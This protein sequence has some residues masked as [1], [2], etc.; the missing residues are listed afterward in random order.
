M[1][2]VWQSEPGKPLRIIIQN[3]G[4]ILAEGEGKFY[5]DL[6]TGKILRFEELVG[7][8]AEAGEARPAVKQG[9]RFIRI[10]AWDEL[11]MELKTQRDK[12]ER[13][14]DEKFANNILPP[15]QR[16]DFLQYSDEIREEQTQGNMALNW[17]ASLRPPFPVEMVDEMGE[18]GSAHS[19][20]ED[21]VCR[22]DPESGTWSDD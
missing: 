15:S 2:E 22:Y 6:K 18:F 3:L 13:D 20:D 14:R 21:I 5:L 7:R 12:A 11:F 19:T 4:R 1:N 17:I 9:K 10:P 16:E 8:E